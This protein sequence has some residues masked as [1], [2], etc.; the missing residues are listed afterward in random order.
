[1]HLL[2]FVQGV[3]YAL[4]ARPQSALT[5]GVRLRATPLTVSAPCYR[6]TGYGDVDGVLTLMQNVAEHYV[7]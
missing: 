5:T 6:C 4:A 3:T 7:H 2:S 1:M